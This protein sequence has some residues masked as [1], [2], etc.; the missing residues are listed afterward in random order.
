MH[1]MGKAPIS[2]PRLDA[3]HALHSRAPAGRYAAMQSPFR[4][5]RRSYLF[6]SRPTGPRSLP[7]AMRPP[8]SQTRFLPG[9]SSAGRSLNEPSAGKIVHRPKPPLSRPIRGTIGS[10]GAC[11]AD[12]RPGSA[13]HGLLAGLRPRPVKD[14][15]LRG[16]KSGLP[17]LRGSSLV[18][19]GTPLRLSGP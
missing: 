4:A 3:M 2:G 5:K 1:A 9:P 17:M 11:S 19:T 12:R 14:K 18:R 10:R 16:R 8:P 13:S 7:A 15:P 6:W